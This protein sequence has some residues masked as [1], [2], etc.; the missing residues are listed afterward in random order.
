VVAADARRRLRFYDPDRNTLLADLETPTRVWMLRLSPDGVR[1]IT[2]P[3]PTGKAAPPILW[4]LVRYCRIAQ[5]DGH[6]GFVFSARFTARSVVSAGGDGTAR[7]WDR[8]TGRLLETYR[9]TSRFLKDAVIDPDQA[10]LIA[11]GSEGLLWFWELSTGRPL[12]KL[13]A[14]RS[15]AIGI[16]IEGSALITRGSTGE[17]SRWELASPEGLSRR[18]TPSRAGWTQGIAISCPNEEIDPKASGPSRNHSGACD[19]GARACHWR[20]RGGGGRD[21]YVQGELHLPGSR[22]GA[23]GRMSVLTPSDF[24]A[25][26]SRRNTSGR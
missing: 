24:A 4:D 18:C 10:L 2:I 26:R 22:Q 12:W 15:H 23:G 7:L 9:S 5:L 11:G 8:D 17:I 3:W 20:R 21:R 14:H 13:Q 1:L 19:P 6:T 16:H 25:V